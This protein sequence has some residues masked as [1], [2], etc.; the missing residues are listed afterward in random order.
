MADRQQQ[1]RGKKATLPVLLEG[2]LGYCTDT[3]ELYIGSAGGNVL[4]GSGEFAEAIDTLTTDMA[5][6]LTANQAAS[7]NTLDAGADVAAAVSC[8]NS[9]INSLKT[10]GIMK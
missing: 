9:L 4:V 3:K 10:A 7:V 1:F 8:I 5:K 2:E 6:K